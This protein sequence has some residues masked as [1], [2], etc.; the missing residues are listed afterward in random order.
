MTYF[1]N[2][3]RQQMIATREAL[4]SRLAPVADAISQEVSSFD[5]FVLFQQDEYH[6]DSAGSIAQINA[7]DISLGR[8]AFQDAHV[9]NRRVDLDVSTLGQTFQ[10]GR[11]ALEESRMNPEQHLVA[12]IHIPAHVG[13]R[14]ASVFQLAFT[15]ELGEP[16]RDDLAMIRSYWERVEPDCIPHLEQLYTLAEVFP[17]HSVSDALALDTPTTPNAF[18][19][20]WDTSHSRTQAREQYGMLRSDLT[21]RGA[22]FQD[23]VERYEGRLMRPTGD[24]QMFALEIPAAAYDRLSDSSIRSFATHSL[25]PMVRELRRAADFDNLP[26]IRITAE[27]GRV[28]RTTFDESSQSIFEMADV[29]DKQPHDHTTVA[30]GQRALRVLELDKAAVEGLSVSQ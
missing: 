3:H 4:H 9:V 26:P 8:L 24:G 10:S 17:N 23:I 7:H 15:R 30:F 2:Q 16:T 6:P 20:G 5:G 1:S 28:E 12:G 21:V 14:A 18:L 29:S 22:L 13:R 27:L 25:I 19:V 11:Y